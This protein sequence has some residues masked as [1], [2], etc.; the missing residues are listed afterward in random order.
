MD[1]LVDA[2]A[3]EGSGSVMGLKSDVEAMSCTLTERG[4]ALRKWVRSESCSWVHAFLP[5][6]DSC[7]NTGSGNRGRLV[8]AA[9]MDK[10]GGSGAPSGGESS[11]PSGTGWSSV[12]C[13]PREGLEW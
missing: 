5:A 4:M 3:P 2:V 13:T 12:W 7:L 1:G 9:L 10:G 11:A 8:S 6:W